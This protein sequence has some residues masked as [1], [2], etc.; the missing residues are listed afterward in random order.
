MIA[1]RSCRTFNFRRE[2]DDRVSDIA[3]AGRADC[4]HGMGGMFVSAEIIQFIPRPRHD[5]EQTDFP[6]IDFRSAMQDL[7]LGHVDTAPC[8]CTEPDEDAT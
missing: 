3:R 2:V 4:H 1:W 5:N 7:P 6:V 8:E